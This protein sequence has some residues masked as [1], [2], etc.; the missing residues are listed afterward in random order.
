MNK[1]LV[2]LTITATLMLTACGTFAVPG[3]GQVTVPQVDPQQVLK[4]GDTHELKM[5]KEKVKAAKDLAPPPILEIT[6][7]PNQT[8][9]FKGV[10]SLKVNAPGTNNEVASLIFQREPS[11][12]EK[13]G[14]FFLRGLEVIANPLVTLK[15]G[16]ENA[17]TQRKQIDANVATHQITLGTVKDVAVEGINKPVFAMPM[18]GA[19][20]PAPTPAPAEPTT[21][22][23]TGSVTGQ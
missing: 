18:P 15:V 4:D 14:N 10:Q 17:I 3:V 16:K 1:T 19:H 6:A 9:E 22:P 2:T 23:A 5:F 7:L 20:A 13:A 12:L 11:A 21:P 8:I